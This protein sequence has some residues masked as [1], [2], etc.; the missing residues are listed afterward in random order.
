MNI[1]AVDDD[2]IA[3]EMIKSALSRFGHEVITT[4]SGPAALER[5]SQFP[6]RMVITDWMMD[7]MD[8]IQLCRAIR[9]RKLSRYVY[10]IMLSSRDD[11]VDVA[12]GIAAGADD[13]MTKPFDTGE[14][15]ARIKA[16]ERALSLE[17][18]DVTIFALARLAESRDQETGMHLERTRNYVKVIAEELSHKASLESIINADFVQML[19]DTSPLHDIG[20]V[21]I[22]DAILLK[23]GKLTPDEYDVMKRHAVI[24]ASTLDEVLQSYPGA[25]FLEMARDI[26]ATHH[27]R[28]DGRG[29]PRGLSAEQIPWAGRIMAIA[30]VYDAITSRRV[31]KAAQSHDHA[32]SVIRNESGRQFDPR[33]VDAFFERELEILNIQ[34]HFREAEDARRKLLDSQQRAWNW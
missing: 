21:A 18:R 4:T 2:P 8:G 24:G 12:E 26:A 11:T 15:V 7:S 6:I 22:P 31:Y 30:D 29:Y 16:G 27:E 13:F 1:L 28:F 19:Y 33:V 23:P 25:E 20:K 3:L 9:N 32:C 34:S 5:L 14:L 17:T 10:V